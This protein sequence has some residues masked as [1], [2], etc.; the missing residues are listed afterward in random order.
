VTETIQEI[1]NTAVISVRICACS[2]FVI[3]NLMLTSEES[4]YGIH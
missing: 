1:Y 4:S 2:W 3:R